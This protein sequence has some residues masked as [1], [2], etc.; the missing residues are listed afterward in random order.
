MRNALSLLLKLLLRNKSFHI[1]T[2]KSTAAFKDK[3]L[4][5]II[6]DGK[7]VYEEGTKAVRCPITSDVLL[8]VIHEITDD[9]EGINVKVA[10]CV[11]FAAFYV[12]YGEFTWD[13]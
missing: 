13:I 10:L 2:G 6:R 5:L 3:S 4:N 7:W 12:R 9:E 1:R 11:G 8:R